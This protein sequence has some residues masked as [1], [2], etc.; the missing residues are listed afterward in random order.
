MVVA[1]AADQAPAPSWVA[2]DTDKRATRSPKSIRA[3]AAVVSALRTVG[4][5]DLVFATAIPP[6]NDVPG[7]YTDVEVHVSIR[8]SRRLSALPHHLCR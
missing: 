8:N 3:A 5:C 4:L 2:R 6:R 7:D 1:C